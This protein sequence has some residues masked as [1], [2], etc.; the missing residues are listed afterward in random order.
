[1]PPL[2]FFVLPFETLWLQ[3][4]NGS[5]RVGDSAPDFHLVTADRSS[6]V[7]LSS[8]RGQKPVVLVFGSH[9]WPPF[10]REVPALNQLYEQY[11]D[12]VAFYVVYIQEAHP[13][14]GWQM[15]SNLRDGVLVASTHTFD[16]RDSAAKMCVVKLGIK[17]PA[18]IDD[19]QDTTERAYTG[20]PDRL[21]IID[22]AGRVVYK[23]AAGPF[24]FLPAEMEKTLQQQAAPQH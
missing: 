3:A 23:S 13:T 1:M 17:I 21:Y 18:L 6:E 8:F 14:D 22:P 7:T 24:G 2:A 19:P 4:R 10:R 20:W 16:E 9:T 12:R 11:K 15:P 5:L